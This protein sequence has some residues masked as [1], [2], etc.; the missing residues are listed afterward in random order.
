MDTKDRTNTVGDDYDEL[1][2]RKDPSIKKKI[3]D[4]KLCFS[5]PLADSCLHAK[6]KDLPF[7]LT[8]QVQ[9]TR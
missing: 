2:F 6:R 7:Y 3:G 9:Q 4:G 5:L 1:E 8:D